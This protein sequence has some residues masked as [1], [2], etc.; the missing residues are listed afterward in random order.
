VGADEA[1]GP[2]AQ[3]LTGDVVGVAAEL[4]GLAPPGAPR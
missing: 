2:G 1:L 4:N 3:Q